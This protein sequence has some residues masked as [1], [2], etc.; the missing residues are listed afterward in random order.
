[1][2][3]FKAKRA[4][5]VLLAAAVMSALATAC[6]DDDNKPSLH[7]DSTSDGSQTSSGEYTTDG[8][9]AP[10]G[11][12]STDYELP[13]EILNQMVTVYDNVPQ[14]PVTYAFDAEKVMSRYG[15]NQ[16]NKYEKQ[17]YLEMLQG[18]TTFQTEVPVTQK[19]RP[20]ELQ[21]VKTLLMTEDYS[22]SYLN[23][24]YYLYLNETNGFI[25]SVRLIY[26]FSKTEMQVLNM[27]T[28]RTA[29]KILSYLQPTMNNYDVVK[30]FHDYLV[31]NCTYDETAEY[32]LMPYGAL[33]DGKAVCEGY[34][35]AFAYLCDRVGI[36][37]LIVTGKTDANHMWNMVKIDGE[38]YH[39]D[40]TQDDP[41]RDLLND[42]ILY[43]YFLANDKLVK[44]R[45]TIDT[46]KFVPPPS[47]G[48]RYYYFNR[49][50]TYITDLT[51]LN[52]KIKGRLMQAA[53][54]KQS[55][56]QFKFASSELYEVGINLL[57]DDFIEGRKGSMQSILTQINQETTSGIASVAPFQMKSFGLLIFKINYPPEAPAAEAE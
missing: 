27:E 30:F 47:T 10:V 2:D 51:N 19:L 46:D 56:V 18:M 3:I 38:W 16:L 54:A 21:R 36:E 7:P 55:Y 39:I 33:V 23:T 4:L 6:N 49:E 34:A 31:L 52:D 40:V 9:D 15:F 22:L 25:S 45:M 8:T 57:L 53:A 29:N 41:N 28:E 1:M 50:N 32:R 13:E 11:S 20:D 26:D 12:V 48:T 44:G 17:V 24:E 42:L 37:N 5:C 14:A 35:K 43:E